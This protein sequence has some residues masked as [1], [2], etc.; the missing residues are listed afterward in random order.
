MQKPQCQDSSEHH[1][2]KLS[3]TAVRWVGAQSLSDKTFLGLV[4]LML[5]GK[6]AWTIGGVNHPLVQQWTASWPAIILVGIVGLLVYYGVSRKVGFPSLWDGGV[7]NNQRLLI[8]AILGLS[9][10]AIE[11]A[12]SLLQH[13][14]KDI[15]VPLPYSIPVYLTGG[16]FLELL[17]HFI[18]ILLLTWVISGLVLKDRYQDR[19]F[20]ISA[21]L[22][23]L[24]EPAMQ[25][26][27]MLNMGMVSSLPFAIMLF[28]FI[29]TANIIP[30]ALFRRYGFLAP[31]VFRMTDYLLWHIIFPAI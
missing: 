2:L 15:H 27:G 23:A 13:L 16:I 26:L 20:W 9:V 17:Y 10:A 25:L 1:G 5:S 3:S 21:I 6:I 31:V 12:I 29:F 14:P 18:P 22:L 28:V 19:V 8:P 7:S 24:W 11:I 30:L 4:L